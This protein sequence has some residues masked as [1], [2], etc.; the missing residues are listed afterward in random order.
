MWEVDNLKRALAI[1]T[2]QSFC[3]K[4]SMETHHCLSMVHLFRG[5]ELGFQNAITGNAKLCTKHKI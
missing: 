2:H 1:E 4:K 5:G 3:E